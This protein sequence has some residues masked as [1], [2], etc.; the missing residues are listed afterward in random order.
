MVKM[1]F[2]VKGTPVEIT[3]GTVVFVLIALSLIGYGGYDYIQQSA[4]IDDAVEVE[5]TIIETSITEFESGRSGIE[6]EAN[7]EFRYEYQG[8]QYT[9][10]ELFPGSFEATYD[11]QSEAASVLSS[12]DEQEIVTANVDPNNPSEGFLERQ[13]SQGPFQFIA[14]GMILFLTVT[15]NAVGERRPGQGTVLES[16]DKYETQRYRTLFGIHREKVNNLS[17]RVIKGAVVLLGLSLV[18]TAAILFISQ[19]GTEATPERQEVGLMDPVGL[20]LATAVIA[21]G[22]LLLAILLYA[23]W[24]FT[25]Y[26]RLRERISEPRP[27]SPFKHPTRLVTILLGNYELDTYG[28]RI[29][30]TGFA[31]LLVGILTVIFIQLLII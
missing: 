16:V 10:D 18:G 13:T 24:S 31:F 25:E 2:T 30:R 22:L 28:K 14:I 20:L 21:S 6:H 11:T 23:I 3:A 4:A 8:S 7:V 5:A 17:K 1:E 9:S 19:L 29:Q 15:L 27:P 12:Y 26:R